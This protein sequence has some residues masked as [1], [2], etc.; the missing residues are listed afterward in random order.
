MTEKTEVRN[1]VPSSDWVKKGD[2]CHH[3]GAT[4]KGVVKKILK[5]SHGLHTAVVEWESGSTGHH[6]ISTLVKVEPEKL[7]RVESVTI[8]GSIT[9]AVLVEVTTTKKGWRKKVGGETRR[10]NFDTRMY[11]HMREDHPDGITGLIVK[12]HGVEFENESIEV[13]E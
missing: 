7:Y 9:V 12:V 4:M 6:T 13:V 10:V 8:H 2:T 1:T 5:R 11:A 3:V